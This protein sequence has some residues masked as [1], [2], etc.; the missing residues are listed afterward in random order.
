[1]N[2]DE[3][4]MLMDLDFQIQE[5]LEKMNNIKEYLK[6]SL[7]GEE[8]AISDKE[9]QLA[10]EKLKADKMKLDAQILKQNIENEKDLEDKLALL[11][12]KKTQN[13]EKWVNMIFERCVK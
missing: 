13:F 10:N 8:K 1:M 3:I 11:E 7:D 12:E 6:A 2:Q 5:H 4:Q 9:W